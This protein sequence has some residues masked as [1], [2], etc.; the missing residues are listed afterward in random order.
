VLSNPDCSATDMTKAGVTR[1]FPP[2]WSVDET[3]ACFIVKDR[4]GQALAYVYSEDD[5]RAARRAHVLRLPPSHHGTMRYVVRSDE[6][7]PAHKVDKNP[8]SRCCCRADVCSVHSACESLSHSH[9]DCARASADPLP[10]A[11]P[12]TRAVPFKVSPKFET[13]PRTLISQ[14]ATVD[15]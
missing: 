9:S 4:N 3:D 1:R 15:R 6:G 2:P 14:F 12:E 11:R 5:G 7:L 13:S 8:T 10:R